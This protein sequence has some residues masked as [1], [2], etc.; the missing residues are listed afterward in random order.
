M[1]FIVITEQ[2]G[3]VWS[4]IAERQEFSE[5]TVHLKN[6]NK[7]RYGPAADK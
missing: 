4:G 6:I 1:P 7:T 2:A 5:N 3:M